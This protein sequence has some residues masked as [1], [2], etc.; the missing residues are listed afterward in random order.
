MLCSEW[1]PSEWESKQ[2]IKTSQWS[3][4]NPHHSSRSINICAD[5][6]PDSDKTHFSLEKATLWIE[7]LYF[8]WKK[9]FDVKYILTVYLFLRNT[10]LFSS[11]DVKWWTGLVWITCGLLWCF[12]QLFGLSFWWHPF[13]AEDTLVIK[14]CNAEFLK[15]CSNKDTKASRYWMAWGWVQQKW[16]MTVFETLT[17]GLWGRN[18]WKKKRQSRTQPL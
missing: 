18:G 14:W 3:T 16:I 15:I 5:F 8:S 13:T 17:S 6:S 7:D 1:V 4:S 2:L 10:Q 11:Q 12:Y 9:R